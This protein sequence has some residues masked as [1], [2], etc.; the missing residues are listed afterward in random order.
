MSS[1]GGRQSTGFT[2]FPEAQ[3]LLTLLKQAGFSPD[4][5]VGRLLRVAHAR[6]NARVVN[7]LVSF[8][9]QQAAQRLWNGQVLPLRDD[10][11]QDGVL[12]GRNTDLLQEGLAVYL[13]DRSLLQHLG[14]FGFTGTRKSYLMCFILEHLIARDVRVVVIDQESEFGGI[15]SRFSFDVVGWARPQDLRINLFEVPAG[16]DPDLW[17]VRIIDL[18]RSVFFLRDGG[19]SLLLEIMTE[20]YMERGCLSHGSNWPAVDDVLA[21]LKARRFGKTS[22]FSQ[23]RESVER[24]VRHIAESLGPMVCCRRSMEA[25]ELAKRSWIFDVRGLDALDVE[26]FVCLVLGVIEGAITDSRQRVVVIEEAHTLLNPFRERRQDIKEPPLQE[27]LRRLRKRGIGFVIVDQLPSGLPRSS[28]ANLGTI[29]CFQLK[30]QACVQAV[31]MSMGLTRDQLSWLA[32]L[33][34]RV[35]LVGSAAIGG[36]VFTRI[37]ELNYESPPR[38]DA[39]RERM[40]PLFALWQEDYGDAFAGVRRGAAQATSD[41]YGNKHQPASRE[42]QQEEESGVLA[43]GNCGEHDESGAGGSCRTEIISESLAKQ[44][45]ADRSGICGQDVEAEHISLEAIK[46]LEAVNKHQCLPLSELDCVGGW[47]AGKGNR[48]RGELQRTGLIEVETVRT[49]RRGAPM[50]CV[51]IRKAGYAKLRRMGVPPRPPKGKGGVLSQF[52]AAA[53]VRKLEHGAIKGE[54]EMT[55]QG[56]AVDVGAVAKG[57]LWAFEIQLSSKHVV[58]NVVKDFEVG[59]TRVVLCALTERELDDMK[60]KVGSAGSEANRGSVEY[61]LLRIFLE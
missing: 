58:E 31:G 37:P 38:P 19:S 47:S 33:P 56:K 4:S 61:R 6:G 21:A 27:W 45:V 55:R 34:P 20:L 28:R 52:W 23:H 54:I 48:L 57:A 26:F 3:A 1:K 22:R 44:E 12:L 46:Y 60:R 40:A 35:A 25:K 14:V 32:S 42:L 51:R 36:V 24:V 53:I 30:E 29:I 8:L 18:L 39:L 49:G 10:L 15:A 9:D 16:C 43:A 41:D 11:P 2:S 50:K 17:K 5:D 13:P 59:F 7:Q